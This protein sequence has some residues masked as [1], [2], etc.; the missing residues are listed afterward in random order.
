MF[1]VNI[2][3][4]AGHH[5]HEHSSQSFSLHS[6]ILKFTEEGTL[7]SEVFADEAMIAAKR[8]HKLS[9]CDS[10]KGPEEVKGTGLTD[11]W[12]LI[13]LDSGGT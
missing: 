1:D 13:D 9:E 10:V 12:E 3:R 7:L 5:N 2:P 6:P 11:Y 8:Q 4:A